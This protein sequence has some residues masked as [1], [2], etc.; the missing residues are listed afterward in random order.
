MET[1]LPRWV[2]V[3]GKDPLIPYIMPWLQ[4]PHPELGET[5]PHT[6]QLVDQL[7]VYFKATQRSELMFHH[8]G[9]KTDYDRNTDDVYLFE[10]ID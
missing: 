4:R 3:Y 9:P 10:R 2:V 1:T 6:Y 5:K 7:G 8:F